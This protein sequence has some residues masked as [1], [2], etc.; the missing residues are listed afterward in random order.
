MEMS[1][2][3]ARPTKLERILELDVLMVEG[4]KGGECRLSQPEQRLEPLAP[5]LAHGGRVILPLI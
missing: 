1:N 4:E 3:R 5:A 2:W